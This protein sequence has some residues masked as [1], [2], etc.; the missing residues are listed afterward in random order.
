MIIWRANPAIDRS[1]V[2]AIS[3]KSKP[4]DQVIKNVKYDITGSSHTYETYVQENLVNNIV[5]L[6]SQL[7]EYLKK[8][9]AMELWN[10]VNDVSL[11]KKF[12]VHKIHDYTSELLELLF[13]TYV[14]RIPTL[15]N[16]YFD[17]KRDK[18]DVAICTMKDCPERP[19]SAVIRE[20]MACLTVYIPLLCDAHYNDITSHNM[21]PRYVDLR[22]FTHLSNVQEEIPF[23]QSEIERLND[24]FAHK[25][26]YE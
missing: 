6:Q 2:P 9:K 26:W 17:F 20:Y 19:T 7:F 23:F 4:T 11:F 22:L 3:F 21:I 15:R 25:L 18:D 14:L 24:M 13:M 8:D 12:R 16:M 1:E 10:Y 5:I